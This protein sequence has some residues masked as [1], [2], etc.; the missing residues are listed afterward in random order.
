MRRVT[1]IACAVGLLAA[2]AAAAPAGARTTA[3]HFT[4][5]GPGAEAYW[6]NGNVTTQL[7]VFDQLNAPGTQGFF[8]EVLILRT[9]WNADDTPAWQALYDTAGS[10]GPAPAITIERPLRWASVDGTVPL[11][12]C[13]YGTCPALPSAV[14]VSEEWTGEGPTE[15]LI[16]RTDWA[17]DPGVILMTSHNASFFRDAELAQA[18][19]FGGALGGLGE[20]S[21][22]QLF[23][24]HIAQV[25]ICHP[26]VDCE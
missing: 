25:F 16:A 19:P 8:E 12:G 14:E 24:V 10:E 23:D 18:D 15:R 6:A 9:G 1:A 11:V 4:A 26:G 2:M 3:D 17:R 5:V 20:L 22:A 21:T 13:V 7:L